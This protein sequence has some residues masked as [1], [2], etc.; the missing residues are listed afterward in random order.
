MIDKLMIAQ[1]TSSARSFDRA[2]RDA[3]FASLTSKL[4]AWMEV[5]RGERANGIGGPIREATRDQ[6]SR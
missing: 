5:A 2:A 4:D 3:L 1:R 6:N